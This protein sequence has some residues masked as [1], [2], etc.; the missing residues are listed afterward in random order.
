MKHKYTSISI[1]M[2][3]ALIAEIV[4]AQ[5]IPSEMFILHTLKNGQKLSD[6]SEIYRISYDDI[7]LSNKELEKTGYK[8]GMAIKIPIK[9]VASIE[10]ISENL[11]AGET[12]SIKVYTAEINS[13]DNKFEKIKI[14]TKEIDYANEQSSVSSDSYELQITYTDN[15]I[16]KNFSQEEVHN[17]LNNLKRMSLARRDINYAFNKFKFY[18]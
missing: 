1:L 18:K 10:L 13:T 15:E 8:E 11:P 5:S 4:T 6:L 12:K 2:F 16:R 14:N 7:L 9:D 3:L 17:I